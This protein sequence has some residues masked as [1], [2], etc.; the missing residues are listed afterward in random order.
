M[1]RDC[2]DE[3][4]GL[5]QTIRFSV[6]SSALG[7]VLVAS[8]DRGLCAVLIGDTPAELIADLEERFPDAPLVEQDGPWVSNVLDFVNHATNASYRSVARRRRLRYV[9]EATNRKL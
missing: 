1:N 8:T 7:L 9:P 6:A 5:T 2:H 3:S 4:D